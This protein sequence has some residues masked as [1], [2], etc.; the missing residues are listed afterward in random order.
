[1]S[2]ILD[3]LS[4]ILP[5][6]N[7]AKTISRTLD[8]LISLQTSGAEI[9]IWD[10]N[11]IDDTLSVISRHP[12]HA[13]TYVGSDDGIYDACNRLISL[14]SRQY[15]FYIASD[16]YILDKSFFT[17]AVKYLSSNPSCVC[18]YGRTRMNNLFG[19]YSYRGSKLTSNY[20][21]FDMPV[22]LC[23]SV[24]RK[25]SFLACNN[26]SL[27]FTIC[28]DFQHLL[29]LLKKYTF[30]CFYFD[31]SSVTHFS[32]EGVSNTRRGLVHRELSFIHYQ[33][34][35][36]R[37]LLYLVLVI[38]NSLKKLLISFFKYFV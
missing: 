16:D 22:P 4:I 1:M 6:Y 36:H 29:N 20:F 15:F 17:R 30:S 11:S 38:I 14:S 3:E 12:I 26:F 27:S 2:G 8:S 25:I 35:L 33:N 13:T 24:Y 32:L 7:G 10:G 5:V 31:N 18:Y 34:G 9:L 19:S 28:S 23:A 21:Y 37:Y